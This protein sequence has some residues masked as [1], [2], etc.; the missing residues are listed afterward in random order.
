MAVSLTIFQYET[1][2]CSAY[3]LV[4]V[5]VWFHDR[6]CDNRSCNAREGSSCLWVMLE[7]RYNGHHRGNLLSEGN[8]NLYAVLQCMNLTH[9]IKWFVNTLISS[10]EPLNLNIIIHFI[11]QIMSPLF[12]L[13][14]LLC[15]DWM[16]DSCIE[17]VA[18]LASSCGCLSKSWWTAH[19]A[20]ATTLAMVAKIS[21]PTSGLWS[22][23]SPQ[24]T[25]TA[26]T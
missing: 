21:E 12:P 6:V 26:I 13:T 9:I 2:S 3:L 25:T 18:R 10:I 11:L 23:V 14:G 4:Y 15:T 1:S 7:L 22:M 8:T 20:K 17:H 16:D 19:G 24:P 5:A